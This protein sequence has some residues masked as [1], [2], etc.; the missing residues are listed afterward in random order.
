MGYEL[1]LHSLMRRKYNRFDE[2][3]SLF[4]DIVKPATGDSD[5]N[6]CLAEEPNTPQQLAIAEK[7]LR[8]VRQASSME[9]D[10]LLSENKLEQVRTQDLWIVFVVAYHEYCIYEKA[11]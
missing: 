9:A 3:A 4:D 6:Q 8:H 10:K 7:A 1:G 5:S 2:A 11:V